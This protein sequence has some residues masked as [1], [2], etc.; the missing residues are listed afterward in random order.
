MPSSCL[1]RLAPQPDKG[2]YSKDSLIVNLSAYSGIALER[3]LGLI[4]ESLDTVRL[5]E[6][7]IVKI[8]AASTLLMAAITRQPIDRSQR[9]PREIKPETIFGTV[10]DLYCN[11]GKSKAT[12]RR[13]AL[14]FNRRCQCQC[15]ND[16]SY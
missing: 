12:L 14:Y 13:A 16:F 7:D 2:T 1:F 15:N 11:N 4:R 10:L 9:Q 8:F 3:G 6:E 5:E